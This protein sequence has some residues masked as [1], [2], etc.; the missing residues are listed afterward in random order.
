MTTHTE[1][2]II[3]ARRIA[4]DMDAGRASPRGDA[5]AALWAIIGVAERLYAENKLIAKA[6]KKA[7]ENVREAEQAITH[8]R[9]DLDKVRETL[10]LTQEDHH[11]LEKFTEAAYTALLTLGTANTVHGS[12]I[13]GDGEFRNWARI[14]LA[15]FQ[16]KAQEYHDNEAEKRRQRSPF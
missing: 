1:K 3:N 11:D 8:I 2:A 9:R 14:T 5:G 16:E 7:H 6:N 4:A 10:A 15:E 12:D 13:A